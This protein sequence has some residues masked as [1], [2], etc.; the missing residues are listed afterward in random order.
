[1]VPGDVKRQGDGGIWLEGERE[2][3]IEV[4]DGRER[5]NWMEGGTEAY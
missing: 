5:E 1:M 3:E 2:G 4:G